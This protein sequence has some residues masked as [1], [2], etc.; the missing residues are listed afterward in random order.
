MSSTTRRWSRWWRA[1][2]KKPTW[3]FPRGE[4]QSRLSCGIFNLRQRGEKEDRCILRV[5]LSGWLIEGQGL[6]ACVQVPCLVNSKWLD[7]NLKCAKCAGVRAYIN[8]EKYK[9]MNWYKGGCQK[10]FSGFCP[11]R[12]GYPPCPISFF[13]HTDCPLRGGGYP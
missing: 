12:G 5:R 7:Y 10:R 13:E 1:S 4:N 8:T 6:C 2:L 11:L 3:D 9:N